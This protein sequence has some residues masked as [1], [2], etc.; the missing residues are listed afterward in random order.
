MIHWLT[1]NIP[2]NPQQRIQQPYVKR[3]S[4]QFVV[5]IG[6]QMIQ[7]CQDLPIWRRRKM[8]P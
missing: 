8:G 4:K 1:I 7:G 2:S 5:L 6:D 3:T